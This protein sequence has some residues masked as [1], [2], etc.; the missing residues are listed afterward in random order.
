M[1]KFK[2]KLLQ[3]PIVVGIISLVMTLFPVA[4]GIYT[5]NR[6]IITTVAIYY[7]YWINKNIKKQDFWFWIL[8]FIA[9]LFNPVIPIHLGVKNVLGFIDLATM[10][11]F[12]ALIN[13]LKK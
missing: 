13:K 4:Y 7:A 2:T 5:L 1:Q 3:W 9:I 6:I 11:F 8:V 12:I 10:V